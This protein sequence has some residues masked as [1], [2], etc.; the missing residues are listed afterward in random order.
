MKLSDQEI[1]TTSF[2]SSDVADDSDGSIHESGGA[3][4]KSKGW[5]SAAFARLKK[6]IVDAKGAA[7]EQVVNFVMRK[8]VEV[9]HNATW[10]F[11][12]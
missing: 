4:E 2:N 8:Y 11:A 12:N 7:S 6:I 1:H 10:I 5:R 9:L 3:D